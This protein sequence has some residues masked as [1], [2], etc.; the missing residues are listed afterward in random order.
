MN[1]EIEKL[2]KAVSRSIYLQDKLVLFNLVPDVMIGNIKFVSSIVHCW[3]DL[4]AS[5]QLCRVAVVKKIAS[6]TKPSLLLIHCAVLT[7]TDIFYEK[8]KNISAVGF[9]LK[10]FKI[11]TP[12]TA[13]ETEFITTCSRLYTAVN[14]G[15]RSIGTPATKVA[16]GSL[17]G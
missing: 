5:G 14:Q 17:K 10:T 3:C 4:R 1:H 16:L 2:I 9:A 11:S 6:I 8:E 7:Q 13:E 15:L 12:A